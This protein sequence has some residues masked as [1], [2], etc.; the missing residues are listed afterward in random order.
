MAAR[1]SK[2]KKLD[3]PG[4]VD[5]HHFTRQR[6]ELFGHVAGLGSQQV[7]GE[8]LRS[9]GPKVVFVH[10]F[11]EGD[12]VSNVKFSVVV[13]TFC[14]RVKVDRN[15]FGFEESGPS[16][17]RRHQR[18]FT[19]TRC[20]NDKEHGGRTVV[21]TDHAPPSGRPYK[22]PPLLRGSDRIF[23]LTTP[24]ERLANGYVLIMRPRNRRTRATLRNKR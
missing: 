9:V 17:K 11:G 3:L 23:H 10:D 13:D 21:H 14:T 7:S 8:D 4:G 18:R 6:V 2:G 1:F 22:K 24:N 12:Q 19:G 5:H 15:H 16:L 20:T